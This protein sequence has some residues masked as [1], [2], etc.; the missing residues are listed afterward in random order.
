MSQSRDP[1]YNETAETLAAD[2]MDMFVYQIA[3]RQREQGVSNREL[4]R[5][6]GVSPP[7]VS[8]LL[9][10][11]NTSLL[12]IARAAHA[13]GLTLGALKLVPVEDADVQFKEMHA[14]VAS[15]DED[16]RW[17]PLTRLDGT[18]ESASGMFRPPT[19]M[20]ARPAAGR[21]RRPA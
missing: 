14:F 13:L 3:R 11:S 17:W 16:A 15:E 7:L 20:A 18:G 5:R 6:M 9:G 2:M 10:A 19:D 8:R 1:L 21:R 12:T 4:A